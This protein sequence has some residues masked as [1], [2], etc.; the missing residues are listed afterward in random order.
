MIDMLADVPGWILG[1]AIVWTL[2]AVGMFR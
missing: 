1:L 2:Y